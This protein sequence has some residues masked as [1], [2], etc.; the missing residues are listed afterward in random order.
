MKNRLLK[1]LGFVSLLTVLTSCNLS[2]GNN[3]SSSNITSQF[4]NTTLSTPILSLNYDNGVVTWDSI[5][6]AEYYN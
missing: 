3:S 6:D 4:I 1:G 2:I 5:A